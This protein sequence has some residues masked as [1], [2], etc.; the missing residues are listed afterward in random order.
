MAGPVQV[1]FH[2]GVADPL[3]FACR[4]IRKALRSGARLTVTAPT[5][6]LA[7]LDQALWTFDAGSFLP[8]ARVP[9]AAPAL[10]AR[11]PV[12]LVQGEIPEDA[13]GVLLNLGAEAPQ[14]ADRFGRVIEVVADDEQEAREARERWRHYEQWGLTP[15][16]HGAGRQER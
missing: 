3:A 16:H 15:L 1:E 8:H 4:L 7:A 9:G 10:L 14:S 12:W 6:R 2:T 11:T 13:P 5:L